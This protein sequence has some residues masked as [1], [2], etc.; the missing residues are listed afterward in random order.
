MPQHNFQVADHPLET[1]SFSSQN[2]V[3]GQLPS[4]RPPADDSVP[5]TLRR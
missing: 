5:A 3:S 4:S 1:Q 2:P